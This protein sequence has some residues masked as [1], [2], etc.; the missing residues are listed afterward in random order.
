MNITLSPEQRLLRRS[1]RLLRTYGEK[2][3]FLRHCVSVHTPEKCTTYAARMIDLHRDRLIL[4]LARHDLP[5]YRLIARAGIALSLRKN[6]MRLYAIRSQLRVLNFVSDVFVCVLFV[7]LAF[8]AYE[9]FVLTRISMLRED[10]F[11]QMTVSV[12]EVMQMLEAQGQAPLPAQKKK[13]A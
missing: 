13:Q 2:A 4:V 9:L 1:Y 12:M 3:N 7:L 10:R 8:T 5:K 6:R 11:S